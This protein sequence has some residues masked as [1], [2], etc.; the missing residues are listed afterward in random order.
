MPKE[1]YGDLLMELPFLLIQ[2]LITSSLSSAGGVALHQQVDA[3]LHICLHFRP[4]LEPKSNVC[5]EVILERLECEDESQKAQ[6]MQE[7]GIGL[8]TGAPA[9]HPNAPAL[10]LWPLSCFLG[11]WR[12]S[13]RILSVTLLEPGC[14][15]SVRGSCHGKEVVFFLGRGFFFFLWGVVRRT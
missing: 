5:R 11:P 15:S 1:I 14:Y 13:W 2:Q 4:P 7:E 3:K 12:P 9:T 6:Q 10:V 8:C